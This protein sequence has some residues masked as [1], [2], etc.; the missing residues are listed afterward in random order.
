MKD[1]PQEMP[2]ANARFAVSLTVE[3]FPSALPAGV[4]EERGHFEGSLKNIS[5]GGACILTDRPLHVA[6]VLKMSFPIQ[7]FISAPRTLAEVRW[8]LPTEEGKYLCG[9]RFLL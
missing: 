7:T 5:S 2:R 6:D 3:C 8:A 9:L 1:H 4:G